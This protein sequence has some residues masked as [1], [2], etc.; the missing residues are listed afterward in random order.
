MFMLYALVVGFGIGLLVGGTPR[1][2]AEFEL[3][4][5]PLALV[6]LAVQIVLF[7]GPVSG[8]V[9]DLGP[10][11][12]VASTLAV[13][14]VVARNVTTA[15]GFAIV[16]LGAIANVAAIV[17]NGGY[18]PV[19]PGALASSGHATAAGYSNSVAVAR[20]AFEALVDRFALPAGLPFANVFSVGDAL[21][22]L[23]I[24][25]VIAAAMRPG[26]TERRIAEAAGDASGHG[27]SRRPGSTTAGA[28]SRAAGRA[29]QS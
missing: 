21:I 27:T 1:R 7:S 28:T 4:W 18:M 6:G 23:G 8:A 16:A 15:R 14:A 10:L 3:R 20:P 26:A 29:G 2:L 11:I 13:V 22:G 12:Y 24:V 25:L 9:G 5:A 17:A 19:T